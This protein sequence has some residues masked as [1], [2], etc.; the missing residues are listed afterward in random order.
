MITDKDRI[1]FIERLLN[2]NGVIQ[3]AGASIKPNSLIGSQPGMENLPVQIF[4]EPSQ[5]QYGKTAREVID[6]AI[7]FETEHYCWVKRHKNK[8]AI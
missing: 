6:I 7:K 4:T 5:H 2:V 3:G 1:D 8:Y